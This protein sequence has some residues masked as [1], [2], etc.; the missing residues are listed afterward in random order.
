[1]PSWCSRRRPPTTPIPPSRSSSSRPSTSPTSA[2]FSPPGA[3]ARR[4]IRRSG[5]R[6]SP[7]SKAR[8]SGE[9][10]YE[11]DRARFLGR[12]RDR[13]SPA[14]L[15]GPSLSNT[16]GTV[17]DPV[18]ALRRRVRV[19]PGATVRVTFWTIVAATREGVIEIAEKY[20]DTMAF[21]RAATLAWT[22]AQVQLRHIDL[23][24]DAAALFQEL[25]GTV[26]YS[27]RALRASRRCPRPRRPPER[28]LAARHLRAICRSCWSVSKT[29]RTST[30]RAVSSSPTNTGA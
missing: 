16:V 27:D 10:E 1:M 15:D 20:R 11:T 17:L 7:P 13:R 4:A 12:G 25:A 5:Q 21:E 29:R 19:P 23:T 14:A 26:L 2:C 18:F 9:I 3:V 6:T 30:S 28:A 8:P 22:H 24:A